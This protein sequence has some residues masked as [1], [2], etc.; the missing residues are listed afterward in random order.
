MKKSSQNASMSR[1]CTT[2]NAEVRGQAL[3]S[4]SVN[5][6]LAKDRA[7]KIAESELG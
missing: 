1:D 2:E 6:L 3:I 5:D 7:I 4:G